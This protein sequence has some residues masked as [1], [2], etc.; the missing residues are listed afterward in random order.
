MYIYLSVSVHLFLAVFEILLA[1]LR[2]GDWKEAFLEVIPQR[3]V[4]TKATNPPHPPCLEQT[5]PET[6]SADTEKAVVTDSQRRDEGEAD[7]SSEQGPE[8]VSSN[9]AITESGPARAEI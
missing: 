4:V 5:R 3:K 8:S 2:L 7:L 9:T 1:Y 6:A